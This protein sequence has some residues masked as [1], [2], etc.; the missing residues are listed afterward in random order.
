[1][2]ILVTCGCGRVLQARDGSAGHVL[3]CPDCGDPIL[4]P[5]AAP[6]QP[7]PPIPAALAS[8]DLDD[9]PEDQPA[10]RPI[11]PPNPPRPAKPQAGVQRHGSRSAAGIFFTVI[12]Y[13]IF[14]F[15][16]LGFLLSPFAEADRHATDQAEIYM[17]E[18][19][20]GPAKLAEVRDE[21]RRKELYR[22]IGGLGQALC[23]TI[24]A[25][26][27]AIAAKIGR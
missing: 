22:E 21:M 11:T 6:A 3:R 25:A 4:V 13:V 16:G 24:S 14:C 5:D 17:A 18:R 15:T 1:M 10:P 23:F 9:E 26:G 20:G 12:L 19:H 2:G 7:P 8:L 27:L